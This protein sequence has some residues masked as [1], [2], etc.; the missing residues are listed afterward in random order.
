MMEYIWRER[1]EKGEPNG[2]HT[3]T[4]AHVRT[5]CSALELY[6]HQEL[7]EET[8]VVICF[9]PR[10]LVVHQTSSSQRGSSIPVC[11]H[12]FCQ[13]PGTTV[14]RG[15]RPDYSIPKSCL[16]QSRC[17]CSVFF[18]CF[19]CACVIFP[20]AAEL[21]LREAQE[22]GSI[23]LLSKGMFILQSFLDLNPSTQKCSCDTHPVPSLVYFTMPPQFAGFTAR[24]PF[25]VLSSWNG[26]I[27]RPLTLVNSP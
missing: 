3:H 1:T 7:A 11:Q 23:L 22:T 15:S 19:F 18:F 27:I 13:N 14:T 8:Y 26:R 6:C 2:L 4:H 21:K 25:F 20:L 5:L 10:F 17:C 24:R 9:S 12:L 16:S